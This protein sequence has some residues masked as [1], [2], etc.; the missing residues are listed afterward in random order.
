MNN[1]KGIHEEDLTWH[2]FERCFK[3]KYL[4]ER[5]YDDKAKEFY[6]FWMGSMTDDEYTSRFLELLRYVPYLR[7]EKAKVWIFISGIP[8]TYREWIE[9][10]EP[11]YLEEAIQT[12]KHCYE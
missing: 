5:Y 4:S 10:D 9:F 6:E 2:A 3:K 1:V 12:L 7:E 8:I 11:R